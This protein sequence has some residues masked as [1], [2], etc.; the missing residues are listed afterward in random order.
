[1]KCEH[2]E[3]LFLDYLNNTLDSRTQQEV[4]AHLATCEKCKK[5]LANIENLWNSLSSVPEEDP[6][7]IVRDRFYAMLEAYKQ[8]LQQAAAHTPWYKKLEQWLGKWWP[9]QPA[10][11]FALSMVVLLIGVLIG[12]GVQYMRPEAREISTLRTEVSDMRQMVTLSML[13]KSSPSERIR[14]VNISTMV[15]KPGESLLDA[16]L[17]TLNSDP[18][19]NVRLAAVDALYIFRDQQGVRASLIESLAGQDSPLVQ[20]ATIDLLVLMQEKKSLDALRALTQQQNIIPEVKNRA[21]WGI[22]QLI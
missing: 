2:I 20:I 14:G 5:E 18:N 8:G 11:Q 1:M 12:T 4:E 13:E 22:Q 7:P 9:Q 21:E 6:P 3:V 17:N 10:V 19:I 15:Q 16:L